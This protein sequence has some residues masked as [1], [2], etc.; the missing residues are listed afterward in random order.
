MGRFLV[1]GITFGVFITEALIHYNMGRMKEENAEGRQ[2]HFQLPPPKEL[3]KIAAVTGAFS[4]VSGVLI[5]AL[6][7]HMPPKV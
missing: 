4:I 6:N 5:G 7:K 1:T 2:A 3:A